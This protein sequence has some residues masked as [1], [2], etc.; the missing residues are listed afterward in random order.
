[1]IETTT[2]SIIVG[3]G[4]PAEHQPTCNLKMMVFKRN[5]LF[6]VF[7]FYVSFRGSIAQ[8]NLVKP[9]LVATHQLIQ[10]HFR[11]CQC[12]HRTGCGRAHGAWWFEKKGEKQK[13]VPSLSHKSPSIC[14]VVWLSEQNIWWNDVELA[15]LAVHLQWCF[16]ICMDMLCTKYISWWCLIKVKFY[17]NC[18]ALYTPN[19][20]P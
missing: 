10:S 4:I 1:M 16:R 15:L 17:L 14:F 13:L 19:P 7:R 8:W 3:E 12:W 5:F 9:C 6:K 2:W 20:L 18:L 11:L